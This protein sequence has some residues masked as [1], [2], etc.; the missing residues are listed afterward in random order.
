MAVS[1]QPS[2]WRGAHCPFND[3]DFRERTAACRAR[4]LIALRRTKTSRRSP[5][6]DSNNSTILE[7]GHPSRAPSAVVHSK[8]MLFDSNCEGSLLPEAHIM[9]MVGTMAAG[10]SLV[11]VP[12]LSLT[13]DLL[14]E[15]RRGA[16]RQRQP[17]PRL[18]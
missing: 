8:K 10:L 4:S 13:A 17:K 15:L 1:P 14:E 12:L 16:V 2:W 9:R 7:A 5:S 11:L 18:K 3:V 6:G